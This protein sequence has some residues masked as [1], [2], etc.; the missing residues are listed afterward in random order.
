LE[1]LLAGLE[2]TAVAQT[3]RS[4]RWLYA[5]TNA[6]HIFGIALL[7]GAILPLNL[8]LLGLWPDVPRAKLVRVLV[9]VAATGLALAIAAGGLLFAVRAR[10]YAGIGFLQ[11]KLVLVATGALA[12]LALHHAHGFL[13]ET[14]PDRR[15]TGH[16]LLSLVCWPAALV[17]GR[18]IAFAG[19]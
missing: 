3:L 9:P 12:A 1:A 13:L 10:E 2:G 7:V 19:D 15:L 16:A 17:C 14:A 18:L 8:R 11:L 5:A 6:A 4:S